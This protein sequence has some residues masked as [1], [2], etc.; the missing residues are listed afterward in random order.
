M[1][2]RCVPTAQCCP[3]CPSHAA[4][5]TLYTSHLEVGAM[6][7]LVRH[8]RSSC[9][10]RIVASFLATHCWSGSRLVEGAALG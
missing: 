8:R 6:R 7:T 10:G 5:L 4:T 3:T 9:A 1:P 2:S